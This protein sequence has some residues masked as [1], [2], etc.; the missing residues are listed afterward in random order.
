M[1]YWSTLPFRSLSLGIGS[2]DL[3]IIQAQEM[4]EQKYYV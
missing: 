2:V 3:D 1:S 4:P